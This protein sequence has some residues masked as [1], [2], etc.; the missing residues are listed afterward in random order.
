[1]NYLVI[2]AHPNM[3]SLNHSVLEETLKL[4]NSKE[5]A[6][7]QVID[8]YGEN[9]DPRL[10][11]DASHP[12]RDMKTREETEKYR[13]SILWANHIVF[14]YPIWWGRAPAILLGFI[15]KIFVSGFAYH[16]PPTALL[17][18]GLLKGKTATVITTQKGPAFITRLVFKDSH[19]RVMK[20]QVLQFCGIKKVRFLE[21]GQ[22][23]AMTPER[24]SKVQKKIQKLFSR[25]KDFQ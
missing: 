19:R 10:N 4:L 13:N 23:E 21:I 5:N 20:K 15:D 8:L 1:M 22:S 12:R 14:I 2:Y 3:N 11:F 17:P 9:F 25:Q 18:Q 7:V 6:E 16:H 24:F